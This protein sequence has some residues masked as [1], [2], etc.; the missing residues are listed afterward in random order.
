MISALVSYDLL[1]GLGTYI[2]SERAISNLRARKNRSYTASISH[3]PN[4]QHRKNTYEGNGI[5]PVFVASLLELCAQL[6]DL[7]ILLRGR[8][9]WVTALLVGGDGGVIK[10]IILGIQILDSGGFGCHD[11]VEGGR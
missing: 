5:Q 2:F 1:Q 7:G 3:H 10:M 9:A 4:P 11:G 8:V 6:E